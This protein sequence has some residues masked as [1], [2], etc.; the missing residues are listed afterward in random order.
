MEEK[1]T[2]T[3]EEKQANSCQKCGKEFTG[4][5]CSG[6]GL[7]YRPR[8]SGCGARLYF[9]EKNLTCPQCGGKIKHEDLFVK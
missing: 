3:E 5:A 7:K 6:C 4:K 9:D 8:C 1:N 2:K